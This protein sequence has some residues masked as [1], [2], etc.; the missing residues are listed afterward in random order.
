MQNDCLKS[1]PIDMFTFH[2][3]EMWSQYTNPRKYKVSHFNPNNSQIQ[4]KFRIQCP[5]CRKLTHTYDIKNLLI[6]NNELY[7]ITD[8]SEMEKEVLNE[9]QFSLQKNQQDAILGRRQ[10]NAYQIQDLSQPNNK[11]VQKISEMFTVQATHNN[12]QNAF[13]HSQFNKKKPNL[14]SERISPSKQQSKPTQSNHQKKQSYQVPQQQEVAIECKAKTQANTSNIQQNKINDFFKPNSNTPVATPTTIASQLLFQQ[15]D[16]KKPIQQQQQTIYQQQQQYQQQLQQQS[17]TDKV[18][19]TKQYYPEEKKLS[20]PKYSEMIKEKENQLLKEISKDSS[21]TSKEISDNSRHKRS[22]TGLIQETEEQASVQII[23]SY[24]KMVQKNVLKLEKDVIAAVNNKQVDPQCIYQKLKML[25]ARVGD[26]EG[27][28]I[29][30][31]K[32]MQK[33][34]SEI[35]GLSTPS[36]HRKTSSHQNTSHRYTNTSN[37]VKNIEKSDQSIGA[38]PQELK[39]YKKF[40]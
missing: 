37:Y 9:S 31:I 1:N 24:F 7:L 26:N 35:M 32:V 39:I 34:H 16:N 40:L 11:N 19:D 29:Q 38:M 15:T 5:K 27:E 8:S 2:V 3:H 17:K 10:S 23:Q 22:S 4:N 30:S 33:L 12:P 13:N 20:T 28:L 14:G 36:Q 25:T 21:N 6:E 18:F